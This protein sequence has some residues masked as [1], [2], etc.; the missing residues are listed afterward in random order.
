MTKQNQGVKESLKARTDSIVKQMQELKASSKSQ[1]A[2]PQSFLKRQ[3]SQLKTLKTRLKK[4][5][6]P[7]GT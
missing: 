1:T 3:W 2:E 5:D 4:A 7:N 6:S